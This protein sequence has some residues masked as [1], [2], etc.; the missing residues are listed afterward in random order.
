MADWLLPL[1]FF[2]PLYETLPDTKA[3][4]KVFLLHSL[5]LCCFRSAGQFPNGDGICSGL[6]FGSLC[7]LLCGLH[8]GITV[9]LCP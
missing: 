5:L 2:Y 4:H 9:N 3:S 7:P 1:A 8:T 6:L